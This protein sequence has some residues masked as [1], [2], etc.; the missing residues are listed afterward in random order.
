[1]AQAG[2]PDLTERLNQMAEGDPSP[3]VSRLTRH[4]MSAR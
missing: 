4:F 1:M 2:S 3:T